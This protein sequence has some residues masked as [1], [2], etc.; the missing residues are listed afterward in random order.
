MLIFIPMKNLNYI[1]I[2][3]CVLLVSSVYASTILELN[4]LNV[5]NLDDSYISNAEISP[6]ITYN[7][8]N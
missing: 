6:G 4:T 7:H 2:L 1:L 3:I 8:V 5:T